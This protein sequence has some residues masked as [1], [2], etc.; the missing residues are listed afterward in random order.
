M[1]AIIIGDRTSTPW[2]CN[3]AGYG[4]SYHGSELAGYHA[5]AGILE[6][7][8]LRCDG[9]PT[10]TNGTMVVGVVSIEDIRYIQFQL[11]MCMVPK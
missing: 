6:M 3:R 4:H 10:G 2:Y 1:A 8:A 7:Q 9:E 11:H 5:S